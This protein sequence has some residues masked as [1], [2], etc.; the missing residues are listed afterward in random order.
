MLVL[1]RKPGEY[2]MIGQDVMVKVI[3]SE[4]GDLRLATPRAASI[5]CA[6]RFTN[7]RRNN[8]RSRKRTTKR[9]TGFTR[10]MALAAAGR[11]PA[12]RRVLSSFLFSLS[13]GRLPD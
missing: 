10:M 1:G 3:K 9:H 7:A 13:F 8:R 6:A 12:T 2:V 4:D 5:S 11:I